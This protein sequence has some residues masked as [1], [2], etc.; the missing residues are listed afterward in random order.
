MR[1]HQHL[2][3]NGIAVVS[4]N[5]YASDTWDLTGQGAWDNGLD[6]PF[7][8]HLFAVLRAGTYGFHSKRILDPDR[9]ALTG[10]SVGAHM[11]SWM[12]QLH[13]SGQLHGIATVRA[14]VMFAGGSYRCF[15][16]PPVAQT[17][18]KSCNASSQCWDFGCSSNWSRLTAPCCQLCCP[19]NVTEDWYADHPEQYPEHPPTFLVQHT[20]VDMNS[21]TCAAK[22][23]HDTMISHGARSQIMLI[24]REEETCYCL[25]SAADPNA[26]GS[27]F[28]SKC[29]QFLPGL[30]P[31]GYKHREGTSTAR[32]MYH[33]M[34]FAG[35]VLP[36]TRF[37]VSAL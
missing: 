22:N 4:V 2:L 23:Y 19:T 12:M 17:V 33:T 26:S 37:L 1:M 29:P 24:P 7:L 28:E 15:E 32:C 21:D 35:M 3:A 25:G 20:T 18:C 27:P 16:K 14:G 34:G 10:Y 6:K 36:V 8:F 11:V 9:L 31:G 5:T 30:P 13:A